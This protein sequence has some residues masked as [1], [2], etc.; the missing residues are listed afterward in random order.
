MRNVAALTKRELL[1]YFLSPMAYVVLTVFL[2]LSGYVFFSAVSNTQEATLVPLFEFLF[3]LLLLISPMLTMRLF[4]D[5]FQS[6]TIEPLLTA[7]V[8]AAE[9]VLS[10]YLASLFF[11]LAMLVP[12]FVH[13]AVL[14]AFGTPDGGL[15]VAGYL[16]VF[17]LGGFFLAVGLVASACVRSQVSAAV[18]SIVVLLSLLVLPVVVPKGATGAVS[19]AVRTLCFTGHFEEFTRGIVD[20][21]DVAYFLLGTAFC[22]FLTCVLVAVRRWKGAV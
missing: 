12:T 19:D 8:T 2:A 17:L 14:F 13:A 1:A 16:G 3:L 9:V 10:K 18:I 6:G 5:E 15:V 22:V 20:T 7:P 4:A 21:R 11:L